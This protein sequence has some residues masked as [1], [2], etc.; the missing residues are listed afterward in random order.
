MYIVNLLLYKTKAF[1]VMYTQNPSPYLAY[2]DIY[3]YQKKKRL[4]EHLLRSG[5]IQVMRSVFGFFC[6]FL[7]MLFQS[8]FVHVRMAGAGWAAGRTWPL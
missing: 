5:M 4:K 6:L 1:F 7:F 3:I 8:V 2:V